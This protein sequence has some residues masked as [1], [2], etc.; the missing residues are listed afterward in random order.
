MRWV[1]LL[2][3]LVVPAQLATLSLTQAKGKKVINMKLKDI[4]FSYLTRV[5]AQTFLWSTFRFTTKFSTF[6][7]NTVPFSFHF[8]WWNCFMFLLRRFYWLFNNWLKNCCFLKIYGVFL[9]V[10]LTVDSPGSKSGTVES[11]ILHFIPISILHFIILFL[12]R[13]HCKKQKYVTCS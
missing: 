3:G 12:T 8:V 5:H 10:L 9:D 7:L 13:V 1:W 2:S 6:L 11:F 4:K